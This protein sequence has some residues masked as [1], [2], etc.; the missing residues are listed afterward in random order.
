MST[1]ELRPLA[2]VR[3]AEWLRLARLAKLLAWVSLAVAA[4]QGGLEA[5]RGGSCGCGV[6]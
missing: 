5:W 2:P 6:C 4:V 3:S 1:L